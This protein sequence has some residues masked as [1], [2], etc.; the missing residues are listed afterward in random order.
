M[1]TDDER[2][3]L[4]WART[5]VERNTQIPVIVANDLLAIIDRVTTPRAVLTEA[6]RL[7]RDASVVQIDAT[8]PGRVCV[9]ADLGGD[10]YAY[11][12]AD[13]LAAGYEELAKRGRVR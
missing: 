2:N 5:N 11:T 3:T 1:L 10:D 8:L 13:S 6:E 4:A 12:W 7:L 9:Q